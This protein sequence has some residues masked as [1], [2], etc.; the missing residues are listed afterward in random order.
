[1][2][3]K[4][5]ILI[6]DDDSSVGF[7]L[8]GILKM[9]NYKT[10]SANSGKEAIEAIK[11][12]NFDIAFFDIRLP[13]M[14]GV[15]LLQAVREFNSSLI[16]IMMTAYA[17]RDLIEEALQKGAVRCLKKPFDLPE[18]LALVKKLIEK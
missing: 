9:E 16:I 11:N 14:N 7:S 8:I 3:N 6:V 12:N 18:A 15:E 2:Q 13:D 17:S 5:N 4:P 10:A 1:M